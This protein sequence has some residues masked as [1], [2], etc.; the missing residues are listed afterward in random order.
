MLLSG[1]VH[2]DGFLDAC[3]A[4]FASVAPE[5]RL[6]IMKDPRHGTFAI[7]GFAVLCAVWIAALS[8]IAPPALPW[9]LAFAGG[10]ARFAAVLN[11]F[12]VPYPRA[13]DSARAFA[14]RP[15]VGVLA[16]GGALLVAIA[17]GARAPWW[18][19]AAAIACALA[20]VLGRLAARRLGGVLTGDVYGATIVALDVVLLTGIAL[21]QGH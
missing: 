4:L 2:V 1:A 10:A 20:L 19:A 15:P 6:E 9:A 7:A 13:G 3:D 11:A 8:S 16:I 12:A 5:R 18:I 21:L 17:F 14:R